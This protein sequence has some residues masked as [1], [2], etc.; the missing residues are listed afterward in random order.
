MGGSPKSELYGGGKCNCMIYNNINNHAG[1]EDLHDCNNPE[2]RWYVLR[3]LKRTNAKL[4]AYRQL[5][6]MD[7]T[8]FTPLRWRLTTRQGK[9]IREEVPF[10][11]DLLFSYSTRAVLDP[12]IEKIPTLQYR[13]MKGGTY[14][15][16]MTVP[17]RDMERFIR[18]VAG[19]K[20]PQ[21]YLPGEL[22][23]DM[24][25]RKVRIIGGS[26]NGYEGQLLATRGTRTKRIIIELPSWLVATVEI[27]P[28]YLQLI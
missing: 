10:I 22:T 18:A 24:Y 5:Q 3:D 14:C 20:T 23:P 28:E 7:I 26:M 21:Y 17:A 2:M 16:P 12:I 6:G 1:L 19:T 9:L 8:V 27:N 25:G 13:Y 4:P 11:S 15:E